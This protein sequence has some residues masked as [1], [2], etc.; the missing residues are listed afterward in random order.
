MCG[1][2]LILLD[3]DGV[4]NRRASDHDYIRRVDEFVWLPGALEAGRILGRLG[5]P[6]IVV[7]NQR[8]VARGLVTSDQLTAIEARMQADARASAWSIDA[9]YYCPHDH[10]DAC[11]CR[12][13]APGLL[14]RA[15]REFD[16]DLRRSVLVGDSESDVEAGRA[17]GCVT[18]RVGAAQEATQADR[19]AVD[20]LA[21]AR[22]VSAQMTRTE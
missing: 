5:R 2:P 14:L 9:F 22:I 16:G 20:L 11:G 12:K 4:L 1:R 18:I 21:A 7:S 6:L 3:R 15:A 8:G 19:V 17:V 10:S 13:P